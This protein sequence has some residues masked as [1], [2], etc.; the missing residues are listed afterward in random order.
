MYE[1]LEKNAVWISKG[2][3]EATFI[4]RQ[5]HIGLSLYRNKDGNLINVIYKG[6][7]P[8]S[9]KSYDF[10]HY[11]GKDDPRYEYKRSYERL[12]RDVETRLYKANYIV[13]DKISGKPSIQVLNFAYSFF[14]KNNVPLASP[15]GRS[16]CLKRPWRHL[17][18]AI[19]SNF[20]D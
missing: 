1:K 8:S 20:K 10:V 5:N 9:F 2:K 6:G 17:A 15:G 4:A 7:N 14:D 3:S 11:D 12:N 19:N 16:G 13:M 18:L